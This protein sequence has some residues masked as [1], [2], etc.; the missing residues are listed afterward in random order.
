MASGGT[1]KITL[2]DHHRIKRSAGVQQALRELAA[3]VAAEA[4]DRAGIS[5]G[6][7]SESDVA[8]SPDVTVSADGARAHV[9]ARTGEAIH[10][11]K[12]NAILMAIAGDEGAM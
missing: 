3:T 7:T 4:N 9:W 10:A 2:G 8:P 5:G 11:E 6:Y 12:K 1:V